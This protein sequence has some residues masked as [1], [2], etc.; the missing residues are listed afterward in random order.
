MEPL[1]HSEIDFIPVLIGGS[2]RSGTT[3]LNSL[4]CTSQD[5]NE[6]MQECSYFG[7]NIQPLRLTLNTFKKS[8]RHYFSS[9]EQ[10][11][12]FHG[13]LLKQ[14][15]IANWKQ[16][17]CPKYLCLKNPNMVKDFVL[18]S[19]IFP[20]ARFVV[21]IRNPL[22]II[23]SRYEA[24][25]RGNNDFAMGDHFVA[26]EID[27]INEIHSSVLNY[28]RTCPHDKML[29]IEY[30]KLATGHCLD[31]LN[32]FLGLT[33]IG[34]NGPWSRTKENMHSKNSQWIT[35]LHGQPIQD[36]SIGRHAS[37]LPKEIIDQ[38]ASQTDASYSEVQ[39]LAKD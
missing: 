15:L 1:L 17:G 4:I 14:I 28:F 22:D 21:I 38:I 25:K 16:E 34:Q 13:E 35:S 11:I 9:E 32:Q 12:S 29:V 2:P 20:M 19:P 6:H 24:E 23:A 26:G 31:R 33:D 10:L 30:E 5:V 7:W 3:L 18:L 27:N 37:V 8:Q 39:Q 36:T